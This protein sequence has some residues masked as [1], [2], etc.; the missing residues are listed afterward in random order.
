[1]PAIDAILP[2]HPMQCPHC[3]LELSLPALQAGQLARCPRCDDVLCRIPLHATDSTLAYAVSAMIFLCLS[4]AFPLLGMTVEGVHQQI[5]IFS[6]AEILFHEDFVL[7][8]DLLLLVLL[9]TPALFLVATFYVY[10]A[11]RLSSRWLGLRAAAQLAASS[12]PWMMVDVFA[13]AIL[14]SMIKLASLAEIHF[15]LSFWSLLLFSLSLTKTASLVDKHWLN[16]KLAQLYGDDPTQPWADG[17]QSCPACDKRNPKDARRCVRCAH[18]LSPRRPHSLQ[19]TVGL[20][21]TAAILYIPANLYPIM[22]TESLRSSEASTILEGVVIMWKLGSYPIALIIF[23]ASVLVPIAKFAALSLLC[24]AV[25]LRKGAGETVSARR[26]TQLYRVTELIGRWSMVDVFVV[27]I[28]VALV[29][30]G[31]I[32]SVYPGVAALSFTGVV[33]FTMLAAMSFDI[34]LIWD[35]RINKENPAHD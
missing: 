28:L 24:I 5:T 32:M 13:L 27:A 7:I 25:G 20:L 2:A 19:L 8:A 14:V 26:Y 31:K 23:I 6:S 9:F 1:M 3:D 16:F 35:K 15:G 33:V 34:R 30:M 4:F 11:L 22:L 29:R 17:E 12:R 18:R 21:L 10:L